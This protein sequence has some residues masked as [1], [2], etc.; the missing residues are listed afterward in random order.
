MQYRLAVANAIVVFLFCGLCIGAQEPATA[1][2]NALW[3]DPAPSRSDLFYGAGGQ[4]DAPPAGRFT[5]VKEDL[6]GTQP[7]FY[8]RDEHDIR[9]T[10]KMGSEARPETA[11][12]R[13]VWA[14]GY[15]V[16]EDYYL[17]Q[18][19]VEG[20]TVLK[21]GQKYVSPGG[22]VT[23]VRLERSIPG[24]KKAGHWSWTD[25]PFAGS[26]ELDGLKVVLALINDWDLKEVNN[27]IYVG[28]DGER[29]YAIGDLGA[30]F[31]RNSNEYARSKG[32]AD[33]Y[34]QSGFIKQTRSD[35]VDFVLLQA[36]FWVSAIRT[37]HAREYGRMNQLVQHIPR[38]HASWIGHV[39][40][41]ISDEQIAAAFRAAGFSAQEVDNLA[42][43]VRE[44]IARLNAL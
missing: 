14:A 26:R 1:E 43:T 39:L 40:A 28:P 33:S 11:A 23:G 17:P 10:V 34:R 9:W 5:F 30:C 3:R 16:D 13:F 35:Q 41:Q 18:L 27:D 19:Q 25:N 4:A 42:A 20:L 12:T 32:D 29:H 31:G 37:V 24:Q 2:R 44:R 36:P 7:K 8:V 38:E 6:A 21:R 15:F 22:V